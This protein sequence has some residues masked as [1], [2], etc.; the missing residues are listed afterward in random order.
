MERPAYVTV[1][2]VD[3][4]GNL[5]PADNRQINFS[6]KEQVNI[7]L[8]PMAIRRTLNNSIFQNACFQRYVDSY[9]ASR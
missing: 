4:D 9:P 1:K 3:K 8:P 7:V 6:V 5:C 2:V